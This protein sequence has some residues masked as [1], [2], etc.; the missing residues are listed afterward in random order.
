MARSAPNAR[1]A[2]AHPHAIESTFAIPTMR[3]FLPSRSFSFHHRD[4]PLQVALCDLVEIAED[5]TP[6]LCVV[7]KSNL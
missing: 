6:F 4:L 5:L 2:F 7:Y 1:N 3:P